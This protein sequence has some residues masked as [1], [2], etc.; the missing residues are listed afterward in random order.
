AS[1]RVLAPVPDPTLFRSPV[2][3]VLPRVVLDVGADLRVVRDGLQVDVGDVAEGDPGQVPGAQDEPV[4]LLRGARVVRDAGAERAP[5]RSEEHTSEL[6][7]RFDL[8]C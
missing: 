2:G 5:E 6:Q 8:V 1:A 3:D 4:A 7:S